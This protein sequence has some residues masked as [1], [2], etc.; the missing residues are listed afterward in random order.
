[1]SGLLAL[2]AGLPESAHAL[3]Q[4]GLDEGY[5]E[6]Q[7]SIETIDLS[8]PR[9]VSKLREA[10]KTSTIITVI[11][12]E[13]AYERGQ[14]IEKGL[15]GTPKFHH[16]EDDRGLVLYLNEVHGADLEVPEEAP[17]SDALSY[18]VADEGST[19][20]SNEI[21]VD[22]LGYTDGYRNDGA[23]RLENQELHGHILELT[24][25]L[26][27]AYSEPV[28]ITNDDEV[29]KL[30]RRIAELDSINDQ[31]KAHLKTV[32]EH[33]KV[34][35]VEV[36]AL[37]SNAIE[38][39][40]KLSVQAAKIVEL[41]TNAENIA[42]LNT[43]MDSIKTQ[44]EFYKE[45]ANSAGD[46]IRTLTGANA[47]LSET[48]SNLRTQVVGSET[49]EVEL[50]RLNKIINDLTADKTSIGLE[51]EKA[52]ALIEGYKKHEEQT[53]ADFENE[54][55]EA[56]EALTVAHEG[57]LA[58]KET[59]FQNY[60]NSVNDSSKTESTGPTTSEIENNAH[61]DS[62]I[63]RSI[64]NSAL[65]KSLPPSLEISKEKYKNITFVFSATRSAVDD[66]MRRI[67]DYTN[68]V[69][70]SFSGGVLVLDIS[71]ETSTDYIFGGPVTTQ[72]VR[73][74]EGEVEIDKIVSKPSI[75]NSPSGQVRFLSL[76]GAGFINDSYLLDVDWSARLRELEDSG[77]KIVIYA[78]CI[79][80]LVGRVLYL[81][82]ADKAQTRIYTKGNLVSMRGAYY[83]LAAMPHF[84]TTK[85]HIF[86][87][88]HS[89]TSLGVIKSLTDA[90]FEPA[91]D[92]SVKRKENN[93]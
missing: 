47:G 69:A 39:D 23:L 91:I 38:K 3:I 16:Y 78:G 61:Y 4:E 74:A 81:T 80:E 49:D 87:L 11:F 72:G 12:G 20:D 56:L 76:G 93:A 2:V 8:I 22:L 26:N 55:K 83:T 68:A 79:S 35:D 14:K 45:S 5:G 54:K 21:S 44:M 43:R 53:I 58:V 18:S 33:Q 13:V 70:S 7:S 85:L 28:V 57:E 30:E 32:T 24:N 31:H 71:N 60:I 62:S 46:T 63:F 59:I 92:S 66:T 88:I 42:S 6:G 34:V 86:D 64:S 67:L 9:S 27:E 19:E 84:E 41:E 73:W 36:K 15:Y 75:G 17:V 65:P 90:G 89:K 50:R 29:R 37:R 48:V 1:M 40:K 77:Y 82:F 52:L 25:Q 51:H 10:G